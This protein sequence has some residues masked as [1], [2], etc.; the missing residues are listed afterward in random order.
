MADKCARQFKRCYLVI[1]TIGAD[2]ATAAE[3]VV[4]EGTPEAGKSK[5]F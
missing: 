3:S 4:G 2:S 5:T 1:A